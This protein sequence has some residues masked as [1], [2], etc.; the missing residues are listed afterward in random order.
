[1]PVRWPP[2]FDLQSHSTYSDGALAPAEVVRRAAGAGVELLALTDHDSVDGVEEARA[3][4]ARSA[5]RSS[6]P[7]SC[8]AVDGGSEDV[9][10]LGYLIDVHDPGLA[11]RVAGARPS[12]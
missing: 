8:S 3:A 1:M 9:H 4:A 2:R 7:S 12:G 10:V 6:P 5:S 11:E